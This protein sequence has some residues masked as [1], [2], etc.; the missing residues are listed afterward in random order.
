MGTTNI[1]NFGVQDFDYKAIER[2][3]NLR[4]EIKYYTQILYSSKNLFIVV[5]L[6]LFYVF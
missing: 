6:E 5:W 3:I 2:T 4:L 1:S